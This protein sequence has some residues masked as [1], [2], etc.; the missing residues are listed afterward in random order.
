M[1]NHGKDPK[2]LTIA[3]IGGGSQGWAWRLMTDLALE[4]SLAGTVKLYD[5]DLEAARNNQIIGNRL[6]ARADVKGKWRYE[7]VETLR[8][9]L[10]GADFTVISILPGTFKEMH[11]DVHLPEEYGI[12]QSVGDTVGPAGLVRA[13][14]TLPIYVEF[15]EAIRKY[16]PET[17]VINYTNPMTLCTRV[18]YEVFPEIKAFGCCHEVFHTQTLLAAM[19]KDFGIVAD[20]A[21]EDIKINVLG[22]NHFTWLD[23]ASYRTMD[24]FPLYRRFVENYCETGFET[25]PG[26][27][28]KDV[29]KFAERV[30]FDLFRR[31][32]LIAAA[33]DR[34]LAEFM[35]PWYLKD[36]ETVRGWKFSL[37]TVPFRIQ[38]KQE[39]IDRSQRLA[40]GTE[41]LKLENTG[42]EGVR[43]MKA[44]LGLADLVT[45][46]NL[47]NRGQMAGVPLGALVE[48]NAYFTRDRVQP[49]VAGGL[50]PEVHSLV[51]R[52]VYNQEAILTA[53]L[54][55]DKELAFRA[56][57]NDPLLTIGPKPARELFDRMLANT[58][59]YLPGWEI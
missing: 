50:P 2:N 25:E 33:G 8:E 48:T 58:R 11:S 1:K 20:A 59:D 44:L 22:I 7:A 39:W 6:S 41:E 35:P 51:I 36:P 43:Q 38:R 28:E 42:E 40:A 3:Y 9:A 5:I 49:V 55:R 4:E 24:L 27:W 14:R 45:N 37:T 19:L 16:A 46:V 52:H 18:L 13:L 53:A 34:H 15:A 30:K 21:R 29:F 12:Y 23:R 26:R 54:N 10:D 17:W 32:G 57:L 31:Y 56:F 47:P